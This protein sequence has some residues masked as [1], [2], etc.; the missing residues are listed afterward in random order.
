MNILDTIFSLIDMRSFSNLWYWI[1]LAVIWSSAS[2]WVL[3]VPF[4]LVL[5]ARRKGGRSAEDLVTLTRVNVARI[6]IIGRDGGV[7]LV[8]VASFFLSALVVLGFVHGVEFAQ[9]VSLVLVPLAFVGLLSLRAAARLEPVL[10]A[11]VTP[12]TV[13]AAL[14]R[15]RISIQAVG[16]VAITATSMWGMIVNYRFS[17]F[18]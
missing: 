7:V 15:H 13:A 10:A 5:R 18:F 6:L 3:G 12:E 14:A 11:E 16:V 8:T 17:T 1:A 4:D 9:A 2:H